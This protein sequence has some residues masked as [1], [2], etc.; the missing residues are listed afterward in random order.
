MGPLFDDL[1]PVVGVPSPIS[2][3]STQY[4]AADGAKLYGFHSISTGMTADP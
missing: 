4:L 1:N 2:G 3:A